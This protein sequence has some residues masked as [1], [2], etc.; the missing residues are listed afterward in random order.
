[1][2]DGSARPPLTIIF[3]FANNATSW[4]TLMELRDAA[5]FQ[6]MDKP[7]ATNKC[8]KTKL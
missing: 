8:T 5:G 2:V 6:Y 1:M 3:P 4:F 7:L